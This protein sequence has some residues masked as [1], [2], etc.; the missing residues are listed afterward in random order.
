MIWLGRLKTLCT[1]CA[2]A[3]MDANWACYTSVCSKLPSCI[4]MT[5]QLLFQAS[6]TAKGMTV[7]SPNLLP[8]HP[9]H[10]SKPEEKATTCQSCQALDSHKLRW[11][12]K[13]VWVA[14]NR[15]LF[16]RDFLHT[17][18]AP[19]IAPFRF[20]PP[21]PRLGSLIWKNHGE[22][23]SL[24][25]WKPSHREDF[26]HIQWTR[27]VFLHLEPTSDFAGTLT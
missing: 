11:P 13:P 19:F 7:S 16:L 5:S 26:T 24:V 9:H 6:I 15:S 20:A 4:M 10:T 12:L 2:I 25:T 18:I 1:F 17:P 21:F 14:P 22:K 8:E 23:V 3:K 27:D